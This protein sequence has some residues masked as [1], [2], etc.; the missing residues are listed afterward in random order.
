MECPQFTVADV[1]D[2]HYHFRD[3]PGVLIPKQTYAEHGKLKIGYYLVAD[4][5]PW[6]PGR[7]I[8]VEGDGRVISAIETSTRY[9]KNGAP[10]KR[11]KIDF[12]NGVFDADS[13]DR[14][15][16][17]FRNYAG[18]QFAPL[19]I[20]FVTRNYATSNILG[21]FTVV[22]DINSNSDYGRLN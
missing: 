3:D 20:V 1:M 18:S 14:I 17:Y 5:G 8:D 10:S 9:N 21:K 22:R 2:E 11:S 12:I 16:D 15:V 7:A 4:E 13:V 19:C 6:F